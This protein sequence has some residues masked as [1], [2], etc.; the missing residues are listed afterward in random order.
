MIA[1]KLR[2]TVLVARVSVFDL[3]CSRIFCLILAEKKARFA[4]ELGLSH[5]FRSEPRQCSLPAMEIG[6]NPREMGVAK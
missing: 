4:V 3:I 1:S 5:S 6:T 2:I